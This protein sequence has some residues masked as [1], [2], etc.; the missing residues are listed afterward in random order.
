MPS[1]AIFLSYIAII[2]F[3]YQ[4]HAQRIQRDDLNVAAPNKEEHW[5]DGDESNYHQ[6]DFSENSENIKKGY[7]SKRGCIFII[8]L[9]AIFAFFF[10]YESNKKRVFLLQW[11]KG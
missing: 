3:G 7:D 5:E 10:V 11:K 4:T 9:D 8:I 1:S 6:S 2:V